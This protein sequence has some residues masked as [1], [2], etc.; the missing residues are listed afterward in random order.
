MNGIV[1]PGKGKVLLVDD[2]ASIRKAV[3]RL[4][5]SAGFDIGV[6]S[7][8]EELINNKSLKDADCLI[9][10]IRMEGMNGVDLHTYLSYQGSTIPVIFITGYADESSR[11]QAENLGA[12]A[13]FHKPVDD[14]VLLE[15]IHNA[16]HKQVA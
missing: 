6:F 12:H 10:D 5:S 9:L 8:A 16:I 7:S 15:A 11:K 14:T 3:K 1:G 13:Y 4:L 2:D